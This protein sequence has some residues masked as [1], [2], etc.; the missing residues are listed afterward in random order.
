MSNERRKRHRTTPPPPDTEGAKKQKREK[1]QIEAFPLRIPT[2]MRL[3]VDGL[4]R[5]PSALLLG[6]LLPEL[7]R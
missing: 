2:M 1:K 7:V 3:G 5:E 4:R 6:G